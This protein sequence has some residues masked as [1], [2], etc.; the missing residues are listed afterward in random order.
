MLKLV[1]PHVQ[2]AYVRMDLELRLD[3]STRDFGGVLAGINA[4]LVVVDDRQRILRTEGDA[5]RRLAHY[6]PGQEGSDKLPEPIAACVRTI[7]SSR[8]PGA[9]TW[10]FEREECSL[11]AQLM[12]QGQPGETTI[13][14]QERHLAGANRKLLALGLSHRE[15]DVLFWV[16][17]GKSNVE[18]GQILGMSR[19]TAQKHLENI[20]RK[21]GV[22]NRTAAAGKAWE[23]LG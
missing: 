23:T 4:C 10:C 2:Q 9:G 15:V 3:R 12:P 17:R 1:Q 21:L 14:L 6:F 5:V 8:G 16:S 19:R 7:L 18:I 11:S 20:F 13:L 22:D